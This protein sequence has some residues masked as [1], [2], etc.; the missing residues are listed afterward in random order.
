MASRALKA[1]L[2][3]TAV[4]L[5]STSATAQSHDSD[6]IIV[7]ARKRDEVATAVPITLTAV[8]AQQLQNRGTN[9]FDGVARMVPG[10]TI[11]DGGSTNQGGTI[12]LRGV[13]GPD[14]NPAGDQAVSFNIDGVQV[15][16]SS[17]RRIGFMDLQQIEVLKGPQALF[18]GK[19]SP[20]GIISVRTA[21][22][23]PEFSAKASLGYELNAHE[24]R[25]EGYISGPISDTVGVRL[26][27]YGSDMRGWVK[28]IVPRSNAFAPKHRYAQRST[29]YAVRGTIKADLSERFK[30]R[31][32]LTYG[33]THGDSLNA[34]SQTISCPYGA[35]QLVGTVDDCHA[36][37]HNNR[38]D[39]GTAFTGV[40]P[41]FGNGVP[42]STAWQLL[43]GLELN[44]ALSDHLE[45][46]SV[47]G[48]YKTAN[49]ARD[50]FTRY[51]VPGVV[52][53]LPFPGFT[54]LP[55][56]VSAPWYG[57]HEFSEEMRL[58]SDF[59]RVNFTIGGIYSKS[60]GYNG[61]HAFYYATSPT[62]GPLEAL[63]SYVVHAGEA[64]SFFGQL[65]WNIIPT[66]ELA[67]GGRYSHEVK[68]IPLVLKDSSGSP[69]TPISPFKPP[70]DRQSF[71]DFSPEFTAT[72]RPTDLMTLFASY[73]RGFLSG[74][75]NTS[76]ISTAPVGVNYGPQTIRGF[77]GGIKTALF[78][79]ALRLNVSA[80]TYKALGLQ[81]TAFN[82][83]TSTIRNVGKASIK[84]IDMD[85]RLRTPIKGLEL[86]GALSYNRA[87]YVRYEAPC[88]SGQ[89]QA[90]GCNLRIVNGRGTLWNA[91]GQ[92][93][94][95]APDWAGNVGFNYEAPINS[96]LKFGLTSDVSF[97]TSYP[98]I[99]SLKPDNDSPSRALLDASMRIAP[100]D[101]RWEVALI[102]RNLTN[103]FYWSSSQQQQFTGGPAGLSTPGAKL[104]D[105][106]A[107]P[108]RA[109]EIILRATFKI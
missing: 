92:R 67:G 44:Y 13:A 75:F 28:S 10:L 35:S 6:E 27:V 57:Y 19:N 42:F 58:T 108:N 97:A 8:S 82:A 54:G 59:E 85:A 73:R 50:H 4:G 16:K 12:A 18:F 84:G 93:L 3:G 88:Y 98:T 103:D 17:V 43:G 62:V 61:V 23:T 14:T 55:Q 22:P 36:D 47:T 33:H 60:R 89:S 105:G 100:N 9:T 109:R 81:V 11:A 66:L 91:S 80:Y 15:A 2:L 48:Y 86:R 107:V 1:V 83:A 51:N 69:T 46:A 31:F 74:G 87:R 70:V 34:G 79:R 39:I 7:T 106:V 64:Y 30:A 37:E 63:D 45:V 90:M 25:G 40:E 52:V 95:N 94:I 101:E 41:K 56:V 38:G 53:P 72:W 71:N 26:A 20:G 29:E 5:I 65:R 21:D 104:A 102:G 78:G 24:L 49:K 68:S 96:D 32:K 99:A 77:E 76:N